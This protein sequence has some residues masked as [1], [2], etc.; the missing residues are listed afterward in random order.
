MSRSTS[1][2]QSDVTTGTAAD[3]GWSMRFDLPGR[4]DARARTRRAAGVDE[5]EDVVLLDVLDDLGV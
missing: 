3:R 1:S 4:Q 2:L 5:G